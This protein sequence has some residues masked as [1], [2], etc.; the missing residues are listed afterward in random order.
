MQFSNSQSQI[1]LTG[2]TF[3]KSAYIDISSN[4]P[5]GAHWPRMI[6]STWDSERAEN[7]RD[8]IESFAVYVSDSSNQGGMARI[9]S[10]CRAAKEVADIPTARDSLH[11]LYRPDLS[12]GLSL[13]ARVISASY[14]ALDSSHVANR[15]GINSMSAREYAVVIEHTPWEFVHDGNTSVSSL[16]FRGQSLFAWGDKELVTSGLG[17]YENASEARVKNLRIV[18][19]DGVGIKKVWLGF[20]RMLT[21]DDET[22]FDPRVAVNENTV[23][24]V[25]LRNGTVIEN[26]STAQYGQHAKV[27]W[28]YIDSVGGGLGG[29][30]IVTVVKP[31][32][33]TRFS[34]PITK[35]SMRNSVNW[36]PGSTYIGPASGDAEMATLCA[37]MMGR[38]KLIASVTC[39]GRVPEG[40]EIGIEAKGMY[41]RDGKDHQLAQALGAIYIDPP[42]NRRT[43]IELGELTIGGFDRF[44]HARAFL[45]YFSI[46][47][48]AALIGV[49]REQYS[50]DDAY[51]EALK[52]A[53]VY[54]DDFWLVP[55][56]R[57]IVI[58]APT[59]VFR[60]DVDIGGGIETHT[61]EFGRVTAWG[62]RGGRVLSVIP[63]DPWASKTWDEDE[64]RYEIIYAIPDVSP[65]ERWEYPVPF[66][67]EL[68]TAVVWACESGDSGA[69]AKASKLYAV[70]L[71]VAAQFGGDAGPSVYRPG[72]DV[73]NLD[74]VPP[75][76]LPAAIP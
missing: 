29:V 33:A 24:G 53:S 34:V 74:Y 75:E 56:E 52:N 48:D 40:A 9:V 62:V 19:R 22:Y 31:E 27:Q 44:T 1:E 49:Y 71:S 64:D 57:G 10:F 8:V 21:E 3:T 25:H 16:K 45:K 2:S 63:E 67:K 70:D 65:S 76:E 6:A 69:L 47:I 35:W 17:R 72:A 4:A 42:R 5:T 60:G 58:N 23:S 32:W 41:S 68:S 55:A 43:R 36:T 66:D 61:D 28:R 50:S 26:S 59:E 7:G 14:K 38:Y 18:P 39:D 11:I 12:S 30:Q 51:E 54:F 15:H 13:Q 46:H 73:S 20:K 37:A